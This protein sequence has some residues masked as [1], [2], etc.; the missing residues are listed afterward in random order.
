MFHDDLKNHFAVPKMNACLMR[1]M[2]LV[3][4]FECIH[5]FPQSDEINGSDDEMPERAEDVEDTFI[6]MG[7]ENIVMFKLLANV[8]FPD[9]DEHFFSGN[10]SFGNGDEVADEDPGK[11]FRTGSVQELAQL[12][13]TK[14]K[15]NAKKGK[16]AGTIHEV[17]LPLSNSISFFE[18][19]SNLSPMTHL[20]QSLATISI[21]TFEPSIDLRE[22]LD[23]EYHETQ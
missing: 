12:L 8:T 14:I 6:V 3:V 2:L 22:P 4:S 18:S 7:E 19:P 15:D 1:M 9:V 23:F 11:K 16:K 20:Q 21:G 13:E 17:S 10:R 5:F